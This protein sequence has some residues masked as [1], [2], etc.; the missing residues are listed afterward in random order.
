MALV[1]ALQNA[2]EVK[3]YTVNQLHSYPSFDQRFW[4]W[5]ELHKK[6]RRWTHKASLNKPKAAYSHVKKSL[7]ICQLMKSPQPYQVGA[8]GHVYDGP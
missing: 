1:E 3:I 6:A 4:Q 7:V 2:N 8:A 5:Y